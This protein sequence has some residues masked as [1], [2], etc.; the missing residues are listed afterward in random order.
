MLKDL[1]SDI[2]GLAIVRMPNL[3]FVMRIHEQNELSANSKQ[4]PI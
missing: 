3:G 2:L 1:V 4:T